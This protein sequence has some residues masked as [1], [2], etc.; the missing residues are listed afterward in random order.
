MGHTRSVGDPSGSSSNREGS[1]PVVIEVVVTRCQDIASDGLCRAALGCNGQKVVID[2][3]SSSS[4]NDV[5]Y[6][7]I[8][9]QNALITSYSAGGRG[10]A[11]NDRPMESLTLS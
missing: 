8:E 3:V 2:F 9:L 6:M 1:T 7:S 4:K 5:P 10:G 11:S